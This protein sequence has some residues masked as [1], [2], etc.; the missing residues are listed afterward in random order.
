MLYDIRPGEVDLPTFPLFGLFD[1]ALGMTTIIPDMDPTRPARVDPRRILPAMKAFGVTNMFGSPALLDTVGRFGERIPGLKRVISAGAPV[2]IPVMER[3]LDLLDDDARIVTPY[4]ATESLP[5]CSIG[6]DE[7]FGND[8]ILGRTLAGKGVCVGRPLPQVDLKITAITDEV[9]SEIR[10]V[11]R[12]EIGEVVV[13]S[14]MTTDTYFN[15]NRSTAL[16]KIPGADGRAAHRMG[17]LGFLDGKGRLWLCGRKSQRVVT[18]TETLFTVPCELVFNA[19]PSV[20]RSA[21]V[22]VEGTPV[23]CVELEKG[24]KINLAELGERALSQPHTA[25]IETFL[26]HPGFPVDVRHNAKIRRQELRE[27]AAEKLR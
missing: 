5:V 2:S 16:A 22:G 26:V 23:I 15:R 8:E 3:F 7:I 10:E 11:P 17:D 21:L 13:R 25:G 14:A 20:R 9:E 24:A 12:G 19:H 18:P 4:G 6:S 27:W 1:P